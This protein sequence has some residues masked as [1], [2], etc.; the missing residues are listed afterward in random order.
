M[1][2]NEEIWSAVQQQLGFT[3]E[4]MV[5]LKANPRN[6]DVLGKFPEMQK[7]MFVAEVISSQGCL[8]QHKTGQ[9]I[10]LDA[11]EIDIGNTQ[12]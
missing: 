7:K 5:Q 9:K 8:N 11:A 12:L 6:A 10:Y 2:I 3:D 1:M 4:E